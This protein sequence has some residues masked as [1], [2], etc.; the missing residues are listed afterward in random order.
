M[1][2]R[3]VVILGLLAVARGI[4]IG[5][6]G[7]AQVS[8]AS[9][10]CPSPPV[11]NGNTD[12]SR[13]FVVERIEFDRPVHLSNSDV[14]EVVE[15]V[16]KSEDGSPARMG[17]L[18][19]AELRSAWQDRGYFKI[20]LGD[21]HAQSIGGAP[22]D[23]QFLVTVNVIN[24][25]PQFHLGDIRFTG[26]AAIPEAEMRQAL[27]LGEGEVFDV[28]R[29]REGISALTKLYN[30]HGYIDF[31]ATPESQFDDSLQRI[32]LV[33]HLNEEKQFRVG[34]VEIRG[35]DP[36]LEAQL[37]SIIIPGEV[38]NYQHVLSF[39]NQ[40]KSVLP[41]RSIEKLQVQRDAP[42]GIANVTFDPQAC[43]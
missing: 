5:A 43:L 42:T 40:N 16:N 30:S 13:K 27:S 3:V 23:E 28:A 34:S 36:R 2:R 7:R 12:T 31:T 18:A 15:R 22:Y 19:E 11:A 38:F 32:A 20:T 10:S 25:G 29:V 35:I 41:S 4:L 17:D 33:I 26:G 24:E 37:R 9:Q 1:A 14:Q 8:S 21:A 39:L 6:P